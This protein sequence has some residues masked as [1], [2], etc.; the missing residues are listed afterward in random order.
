MQRRLDTYTMPFKISFIGVFPC[1]A[2][3]RKA[4]TLKRDSIVVSPR[5][6]S[7]AK[8]KEMPSVS[9]RPV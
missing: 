1:Q 8:H 5:Q 2:K 9:I 3:K 7:E 6:T 4:D